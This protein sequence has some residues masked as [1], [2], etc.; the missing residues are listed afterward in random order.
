MTPAEKQILIFSFYRDAELRGARLLFNL[1]GHMNRRRLDAESIRDAILGAAGTL[2]PKQYGPGVK[3]PLEP[4]VY[5][6]IFTEDEPDGLWHVTPDPAE[7]TRRSVYLFAKRNVKLPML[8]AFDQPDTLNSCAARPVS[9]FAPQALILMNGPFAREQAARM[10]FELLKE[11]AN[12]A[13][14]MDAAYRRAFGREPTAAERKVGAAFLAGQTKTV[15]DRVKALIASG[16]SL[17]Q[18]QAAKVTTDYDRRYGANS[19]SWTTQ[20]FVAAVYQSLKQPP[21]K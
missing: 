12:P 17:E 7:Y 14:L 2:N 6:L 8:E 16:A 20:M 19:G 13:E 18:V 1:L 3:V 5:D 10:A 21:G 15:R 4:E 9:T 11:D